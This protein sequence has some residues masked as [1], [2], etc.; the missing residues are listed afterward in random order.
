MSELSPLI[1]L[2]SKL[3]SCPFCGSSEIIYFGN[4]YVTAHN[5]IRCNSCRVVVLHGEGEDALALWERR[6]L[7]DEEGLRFAP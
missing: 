7:E 1:E 4:I 3:K 6:H 5:M 2:E